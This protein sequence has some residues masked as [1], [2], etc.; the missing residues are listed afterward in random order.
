MTNTTKWLKLKLYSN[1]EIMLTVDPPKAHPLWSLTRRLWRDVLL[2]SLVF[3]NMRRTR[4]DS[5]TLLC[6]SRKYSS[7]LEE[8]LVQSCRIQP[9]LAFKYS[10]TASILGLLKHDGYLSG[11]TIFFRSLLFL[12]SFGFSISCRI[13]LVIVIIRFLHPEQIL[14]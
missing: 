2:G 10:F 8:V 14:S 5:R 6:R 12:S 11:W 4:L 7:H 9:Q 13:Y 1:T 3:L